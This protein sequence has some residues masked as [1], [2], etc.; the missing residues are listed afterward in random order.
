MDTTARVQILDETNC[1][2]HSTNTLGKG[3]NPTILPPAMGKIVGQTRFFSLGETTSLGEG[4]LW[5]QTCLTPLKKWP[6][7]MFCPSGGVGKYDYGYIK[8]GYVFYWTLHHKKVMTKPRF[9]NDYNF[10]ELKVFPSSRFA[11][12]TSKWNSQVFTRIFL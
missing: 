7:V 3:M 12:T 5:I 9:R 6:C 8:C 11:P 1:V 10:F 4:K 2:S